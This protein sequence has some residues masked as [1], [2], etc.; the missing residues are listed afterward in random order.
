MKREATPA[1]VG[2]AVTL[3][4]WIVFLALLATAFALFPGATA[5]SIMIFMVGG[6]ISPFIKGFIKA[7]K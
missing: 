3:L 5:W 2:M 6:V 1:G 4:G 7:V